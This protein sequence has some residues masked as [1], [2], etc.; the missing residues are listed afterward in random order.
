L[1]DFAAEEKGATAKLTDSLVAK[2]LAEDA[3]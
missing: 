3:R 2:L 1:V